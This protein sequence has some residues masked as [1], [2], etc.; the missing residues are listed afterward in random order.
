MN[1]KIPD[2]DD[3]VN[4]AEQIKKLTLRKILLDVDIKLKE[5]EVIEEVTTND[6][7]FQNGKIPSMSLIEDTW[8][9]TG[10]ERELIPLRK[11]MANVISEL[12]E[13]KLKFDVYKMQ[14]DMYRTEAANQRATK[15]F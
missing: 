4:L 13:A 8:K 9:Y 2:F 3:M 5:A 1:F 7:Y 12:E 6:K 14:V 15:D 11:E 10:F